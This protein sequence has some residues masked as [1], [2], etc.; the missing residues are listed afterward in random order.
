MKKGKKQEMTGV[1]G[2]WSLQGV[3]DKKLVPLLQ[4]VINNEITITSLIDLCKQ[5]KAKERCRDAIMR[6][7]ALPD[8][9]VSVW[10]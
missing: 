2:L 1:G 7:L 3:D 10:H 4:S 6:I 8:Y 9:G 5:E